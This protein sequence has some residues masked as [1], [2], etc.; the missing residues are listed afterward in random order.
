MDPSD[1]ERLRAALEKAFGKP[2]RL[3]STPLDFEV[4]DF[5]VHIRPHPKHIRDVAK[6]AREKLIDRD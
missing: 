3:Q 2:V 1:L 6:A 5:Q 4:G